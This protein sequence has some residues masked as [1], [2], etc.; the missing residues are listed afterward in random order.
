MCAAAARSSDTELKWKNAIEIATAYETVYNNDK[1]KGCDT[2]IDNEVAERPSEEKESTSISTLSDVVWENQARI[3]NLEY[4][5]NCLLANQEAIN[6]KLDEI[7]IKLD[8]L[9]AENDC[10]DQNQPRPHHDQSQIASL[11]QC[12]N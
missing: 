6:S 7:A 12:R 1:R 3:E 9:L 5:Q 2:D 4:A 10:N 8:Y 11:R